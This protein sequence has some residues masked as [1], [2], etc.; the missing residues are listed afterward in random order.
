MTATEQ[1]KRAAIERIKAAGGEIC[2]TVYEDYILANCLLGCA[3]GNEYACFDSIVAA[4]EVEERVSFDAGG[5]G[6]FTA[7]N[8]AS[9]GT[10][11]ASFKQRHNLPMYSDD[12]LSSSQEFTER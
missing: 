3:D 9:L 4:L 6:G 11:A 8:M 12:G 5:A 10:F 1:Q 2:V 7:T